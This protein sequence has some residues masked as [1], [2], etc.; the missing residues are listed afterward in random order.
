MNVAAR[1]AAIAGG[2]EVLVSATVK[3]LTPVGLVFQDAGEHDLKGVPDRL[4]P[5]PSG[6]VDMRWRILRAPPRGHHDAQSGALDHLPPGFRHHDAS[7]RYG[8]VRGVR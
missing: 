7:G 1:V 4:A 6:G 8:P 2:S 5:L 3:D